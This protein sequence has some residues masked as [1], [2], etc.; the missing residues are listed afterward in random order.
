MIITELTLSILLFA[1][2][3][4]AFILSAGSLPMPASNDEAIVKPTQTLEE[5][6]R[7]YYGDMPILAEVARC[8]SQFRHFGKNGNIIRGIANAKDVGVMQINEEY[9]SNK[10]ET[11]GLDIYS[12]DGNLEYARYLYEKEGTKPWRA[13][14]KCWNRE[15][16]KV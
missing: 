4:S 5:L 11:L 9:H 7:D 8:E 6:V 2:A 12:L 10:A 16:A 15:L 1:N 3:F 13:S 14:A